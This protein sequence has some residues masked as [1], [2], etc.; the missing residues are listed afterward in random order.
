MSLIPDFE[1]GLWNAWIFMVPSLLLTLLHACHICR[2]DSFGGNGSLHPL[3]DTR[4]NWKHIN[5][6]YHVCCPW[7][8]PRVDLRHGRIVYRVIERRAESMAD[9]LAKMAERSKIG[10]DVPTHSRCMHAK[11]DQFKRIYAHL[12]V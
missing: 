10:N 8:N 7:D 9:R 12:S 3:R 5:N 6:R 1:L 4:R 11:K 2:C